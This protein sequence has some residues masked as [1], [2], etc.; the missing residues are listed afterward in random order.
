MTTR[1][2]RDI[3]LERFTENWS[4][5]KQRHFAPA[6]RS[7]ALRWSKKKALVQTANP[8]DETDA[9]R[10]KFGEANLHHQKK[11]QRHQDEVS[12]NQ[13]SVQHREC[14]DTWSQELFR[15]S[16]S[17]LWMAT[18]FFDEK[19]EADESTACPRRFMSPLQKTWENL[20]GQCEGPLEKK[21]R[22]QHQIGRTTRPT[23]LITLRPTESSK[24]L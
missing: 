23:L 10:K 17:L 2:S 15:G 4:V 12:A 20:F 22:D 16:G 8:S 3:F 9:V 21:K 14:V 11:S 19:Q 18:K 5:T 24:E 13:K 6:K 7:E 1:K